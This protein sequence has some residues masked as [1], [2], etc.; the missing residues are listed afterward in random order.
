MGQQHSIDQYNIEN[1]QL[2]PLPPLIQL[3]HSTPQY[4]ISPV[5]HQP[6]FAPVYYNTQEE[7]ISDEYSDSVDEET[8]PNSTLKRPFVDDRHEQK[9]TQPDR[10]TTVITTNISASSPSSLSSP[11]RNNKKEHSSSVSSSDKTKN[12]KVEANSASNVTEQDDN[13]VISVS[14]SDDETKSTSSNCPNNVPVGD[15]EAISSPSTRTVDSSIKSDKDHT[16]KS[17]KSVRIVTDDDQKSEEDTTYV[18]AAPLQAKIEIIAT[19]DEKQKKDKKNDVET[20]VET[21]VE[22]AADTDADGKTDKKTERK[23]EER[24]DEKRRKTVTSITNLIQRRRETKKK[25]TKESSKDKKGD[26]DE[27]KGPRETLGGERGKKLNLSLSYVYVLKLKSGKWYIG[28]TQDVEKRYREHKTGEGSEWT[29]IH[30]PI[31]IEELLEDGDGFD[32]DKMTKL[33]MSKYGI[34]NVRGASYSAITL[35]EPQVYFLTRE[36]RSA[37]DLCIKCGDKGHF[38]STCPKKTFSLSTTN[39]VI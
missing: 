38:V 23:T 8:S 18:T 27:Q 34:E 10:P 25:G 32:E 7:C 22:T 24:I 30:K 3:S 28:R 26:K 11:P 36:I 4:T 12:V 35:T 33:Y 14:F 16:K 9:S 19:E 1:N 6:Y 20:D 5:E 2:S 13:I 15:K 17:K 37:L 21:A 31:K 39:N 29:K